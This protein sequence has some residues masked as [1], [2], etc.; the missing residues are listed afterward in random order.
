[1]GHPAHVEAVYVLHVVS[2]GRV[3]VSFIAI[4]FPY[5]RRLFRVVSGVSGDFLLGVKGVIA[6]RK[7]SRTISRV[8]VGCDRFNVGPGAIA[9]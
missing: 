5:P 1:M 3:V 2:R 4:A 9:V 7:A 6:G 8:E